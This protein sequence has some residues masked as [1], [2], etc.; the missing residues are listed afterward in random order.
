VITRTLFTN[1]ASFAGA[2]FCAPAGW[3]QRLAGTPPQRNAASIAPQSL[4]TQS[5]LM[6]PNRSD[7]A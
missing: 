3:Q 1:G 5:D 2:T 4:L 6:L 7:E